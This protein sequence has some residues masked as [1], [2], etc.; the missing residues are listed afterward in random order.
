MLRRAHAARNA[1]ICRYRFRGLSTDDCFASKSLCL[2]C[3][4]NG[5]ARYL[6][7][8][9][10]VLLY[11]GQVPHMCSLR[12]NIICRCLQRNGTRK[13]NFFSKF[14]K[15]NRFGTTFLPRS[16]WVH[17]EHVMNLQYIGRGFHR[18]SNKKNRVS[19]RQK[20]A[21]SVANVYSV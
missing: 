3:A 1:R 17:C 10:I 21:P 11:I 12:K 5:A 14:F 2:W 20:L 19:I 13:I 4:K 16:A 9:K 7:C 6:K 15:K 8:F 18:L